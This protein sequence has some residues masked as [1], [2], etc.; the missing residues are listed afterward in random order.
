MISVVSPIYNSEKIIEVFCF[1][2]IKS[3]EKTKEKYEIILVNDNSNDHSKDVIQRIKKNIILLN[4]KKNVGQHKALLIGL[5]KAKGETIV[6]LDSDMED[7][8]AYIEKI[9]NKH[10]KTGN[11][12]MVDL[13]K[14]YL[15]N[16]RNLLSLLFW[17]LLSLLTLKK[18]NTN[19]SNYF[20][21]SKKDLKKLF[22][23]KKNYI[24]YL[25]FL[26]LNKKVKIYPGIKLK[27]TD[28]K[29]S[30]NLVKIFLLSIQ[31]IKHYNF[32]SRIFLK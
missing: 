23:L 11:V 24:L 30:Y 18:N 6:T 26:L 19:P 29:S 4:L 10:K 28:K 20:I 32:I 3:L 25:D 16:F 8:P 21:F 7:H 22:R 31:I 9:F 14:N 5:K 13:R 17:I 27:R 15:K 1:E 12:Y 2:L